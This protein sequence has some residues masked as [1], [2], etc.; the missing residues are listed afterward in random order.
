MALH[1]GWRSFW[2]LNVAAF[3]F[4]IIV[5]VFA[6][7]ETKWHRAHPNE[8]HNTPTTVTSTEGSADGKEKA[9][10]TEESTK[11]VETHLEVQNP[12]IDDAAMDPFLHKGSPSKGQFH[13]YQP[14]PNW[15]KTLALAFWVPWRLL[16]FPIV[17]YAAFVVSWGASC[18]LTA[19]LTQAQAFG[20]PPYNW[21]SQSIGFTNFAS[22]VG[23]MLGLATN[24]PLSD[25]IAMRATKKNGG[26]R[27][28]EMRLPTL[29]PYVL[30]S[31]AGN[32]IIAFGYEYHWD[33]RVRIPLP[34]LA[35]D[36]VH[37]SDPISRLLSSLATLSPVSRSPPCQLSQVPMPSTAT[38]P[39]LD[40]SSSPSPSTRIC[41]GTDSASSSRLG[42]RNPAISRRLC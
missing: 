24:G 18:F 31:I 7:P 35:L 39:S 42:P 13:I 23:A 5:G 14:D 32:F 27:E 41:G 26:I 36:H 16:A 8:I 20:A 11:N 6:F 25:W 9:E 29:I 40:Q 19:N 10:S 12:P 17:E 3:V 4:I 21:S 34:P 15:V 1:V 38:S 22:L 2:W 28:P 33:W 30:I 37:H